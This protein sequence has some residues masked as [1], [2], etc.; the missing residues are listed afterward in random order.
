MFPK[1]LKT[2][3]EQDEPLEFKRLRKDLWETNEGTINFLNLIFDATLGAEKVL[4][5]VVFRSYGKDVHAYLA[6]QGMAP[7]LHG[8]SSVQDCA[9]LVVMQLLEDGW[10]TLFD[11]RRNFYRQGIPE[12]HRNK[13]LGRLE[14]I[15]KCLSAVGMVH[16][17]FWMAHVMLKKGEEEKAMLIDFDWAG[18]AGKVRY[19]VTRS[20]G[21]HYPGSPGGPIEATHDRE[22]YETWR[23][24]IMTNNCIS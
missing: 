4:A 19:P 1:D 20:R 17:D 15:L 11:Y 10:M 6:G 22:L 23:S 8:T 14:Q 13:L 21:F 16:G 3:T 2:A 24:E 5:K 9:S 18:G 12:P 7:Q